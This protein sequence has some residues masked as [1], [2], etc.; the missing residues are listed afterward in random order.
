MQKNQRIR[1]TLARLYRGS[2]GAGVA[3]SAAVKKFVASPYML[4][5]SEIKTKGL[6]Y[7][8]GKYW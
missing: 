4:S 8:Q 2:T 1:Y 5:D 6:F 7:P 3:L